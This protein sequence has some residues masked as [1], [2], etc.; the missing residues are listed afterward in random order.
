MHELKSA[1]PVRGR[2][3]Q[4]HDE[5]SETESS[6]HNNN[7]TANQILM[8]QRTMG[9]SYVQRALATTALTNSQVQAAIKYNNLQGYSEAQVKQIQELV[10]TEADGDMGPN[11]VRAIAEWQ[12]AHGLDNDGKIG[13]TTYKAMLPATPAE[14]P[15]QAAPAAA[16]PTAAPAQEKSILDTIVEWGQGV[17]EWTEGMWGSLTEHVD[18][19]KETTGDQQAPKVKPPNELETLMLKERLSTEEIRR[20]RELITLESDEKRRGDLF[21][22]LQAK[23]PYHNQRDN[24]SKDAKGKSIGDVMCNLTSLAMVLEYLGV[25]NPNPSMQYE[26]ALEEIRVKKGLPARTTSGGWGGVAKELGVDYE[27]LGWNVVQGKDWYKEKVLSELRSGKAVMFSITGH[28]VR[29]QNVTDEGLV[30][31][32]PFGK[33]TLL[34]GTKHKWEKTNSKDGGEGSNAGEDNVWPWADVSK[35][36]MLWIASFKAD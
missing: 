22:A 34:A 10:G 1:R 14:A 5:Q 19:A 23:V 36:S 6:V 24:E 30:V 26:D 25:D 11:T 4:R 31:D 33:E 13:P 21:I 3:I 32:D 27:M 2:R 15:T 17:A 35:H 16:A 20:A 9:N 12:G 18:E 8:L 29:M 28:I 7:S